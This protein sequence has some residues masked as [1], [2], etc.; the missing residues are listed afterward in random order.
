MACVT[1]AGGVVLSLLR[2]RTGSLLAPMG[3]HLGTKLMGQQPH[4]GTGSYRSSR[5]L[6]D[7]QVVSRRPGGVRSGQERTLA[8]Q[9]LG[10]CRGC[11]PTRR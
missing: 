7:G 4:G 10:D 11:L 5:S 9:A 1:G 8:V 3:L 6:D 2:E